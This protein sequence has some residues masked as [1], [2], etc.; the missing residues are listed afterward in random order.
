MSS[1]GVLFGISVAS[2]PFVI[3]GTYFGW[4]YLRFFQRK[5][6]SVGDLNEMFGFESFFPELV[7]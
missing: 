1:V 3:F 2:Y 5:G 6:E 7:A 4:L